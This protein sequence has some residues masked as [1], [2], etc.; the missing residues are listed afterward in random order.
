MRVLH[1]THQYRPAIGGA[2][3]YITSLSEELVRRGH[4][5]TVFTSRSR[6]YLTWR[7]ELPALEQLDGVRVCR[8]RSLVRGEQTWRMLDYGYRRYWRTR[9]PCYQPFIL[10]GNG[11]VCPGL[12]WA[13]FRQAPSFDLI[14]ISN[15]HYA[16]AAMASAAARW[17]NVP[18]VIT[19]HLHSEQP[20][21]YDVHYLQTVLKTSDHIIAVTQAE[22]QY[23]LDLGFDH[24][25]VTTAGNGIRPE[26]FVTLDRQ[27]CRRELGLTDDAF[28][29]LF[30]G[31]KTEYK[32]LDLV[33]R[34]FAALQSSYPHL[35]LMAIGAET[36]H[37]RAM[38]TKYTGLPRL[39]NYEDV[40][41]STRLTALNACDCLVVPSA[42]EAFGIIYLE[43]WAV[44]KP[45]I[46]ARIR[47]VSS[48]I[49]DG[50]DGYLVSPGSVD[51]LADRVVRL[52]E[53]PTLG[54][55]MGE[56]GQRKVMNRYTVA[57]I[58]DIIEGIYM[59]VLRQRSHRSELK[60]N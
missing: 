12:F 19:P 22:R 23:L 32:G 35:H 8:F 24:Q 59:R 28:V 38:W 10:L 9:S 34:V 31:R 13:V 49:S 42:G 18:V 58:T 39:I 16:H 33:L 46:G 40:P 50:Q 20:V 3:Q 21:T 7:S 36:D 27:T 5:V 15:L 14:H 29:L 45:V 43:A 4:T 2:E 54:R 56:Q 26:H 17:R 53:N 51:E 11:P 47:A 25:H 60:Q 37:S 6:D 55:Q 30:L 52:V 41:D 44:G 1:V 57:R 48:V